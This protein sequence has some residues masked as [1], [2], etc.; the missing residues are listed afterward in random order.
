MRIKEIIVVEGRDDTT[1]VCRAVNADTIETH[2]FGIREETWELIDKAYKDRGI[3]I[4]TDPDHAGEEIR[5]RVRERCPNAKHAFLDRFD[6]KKGNNI[7]IE[8]ANDKSIIEALEKAKAEEIGDNNTFSKEDL[9][10]LELSGGRGS[11]DRRRTVGKILGIGFGN[12][13]A[14]VKKLNAY[15]IT[16]EELLEAVLK[17]DGSK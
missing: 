4:F 7:G 6:A 15:G 13:L 2:G 12:S 10:L 16:R 8:N 14:F 5:N 9:V 1:A 11:A 17:I 3:I